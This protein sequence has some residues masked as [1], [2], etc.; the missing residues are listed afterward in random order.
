M[1]QNPDIKAELI[2]AWRLGT[3][4]FRTLP[5]FILPGAPKCGTSTMY[6]CIAAHPQ[7]QRATRKEPTN[8]IH[9]PT[10]KICDDHFP[11]S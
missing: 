11:C 7:V 6:D 8:F 4:P 2:K 5:D 9:Y 10:T 3:A 1:S